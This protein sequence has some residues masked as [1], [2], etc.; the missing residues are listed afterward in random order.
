MTKSRSRSRSKSR[1]RV[2]RSKHK[3]RSRS[4]SRTRKTEK[5]SSRAPSRKDVVDSKY[6]LLIEHDS[7]FFSFSTTN[8]YY[9]FIALVSDRDPHL[10]P[11]VILTQLLEDNEVVETINSVK[12][13][14]LQK[15]NGKEQLK[16]LA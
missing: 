10:H 14:D 15:L 9:T 5:H 16:M 1:D 3:R 4:R 2:R 13:R 11:I 12:S 8:Y 7:L 6:R